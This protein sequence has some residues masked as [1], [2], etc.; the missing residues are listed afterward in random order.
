MK[1]EHVLDVLRLVTLTVQPSLVTVGVPRTLPVV[2]QNVAEPGVGVQLDEPV[3]LSESAKYASSAV[4]KLRRSDFIEAMYAFSFVFANFGMAM[5]ARMPMMTTTIR[6]S[7]SVK[8]LR[9][10]WTSPL[11]SN[12]AAKD[13]TPHEIVVTWRLG[14]VRLR[15]TTL[16]LRASLLTLRL[17]FLVGRGLRRVTDVD[18]ARLGRVE[19]GDVDRPTVARNGGRPKDVAR[20]RAERRGTGSRRTARRAGVLER[21]GEVRLFRRDEVAKV[22]LHRSDVRL[23]LRVRELRNGDGGKNA[24]DD[25]HDQKLDQRETLAI[26]LDIPLVLVSWLP[27][28]LGREDRKQ[29]LCPA[30]P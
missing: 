23:L 24:D 5:A 26:H 27:M 12:L 9:F 10:I 1:T 21:V 30:R 7:I 25:D 17:A 8:P 2:V 28:K 15:L 13:A 4:T 29:A 16:A 20:R 14:V 6:S 22:G 18:R 3:Y 19:A 11:C